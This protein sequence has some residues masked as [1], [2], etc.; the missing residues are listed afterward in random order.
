[1]K[2]KSNCKSYTCGVSQGSTLAPL[3][4]LIYINDLPA[5]TKLKVKLCAD[6]AALTFSAKTPRKVEN[7]INSELNKISDW[8]KLNRLSINNKKTNYMITMKK[9]IKHS[10]D[11][12]IG[13]HK[14]DQKS[15]IN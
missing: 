10:F 8:T 9:K 14:L 11:I 5:A 4:F 2:N 6:D 7:T 12:S 15:H 13:P 1:M 3:L